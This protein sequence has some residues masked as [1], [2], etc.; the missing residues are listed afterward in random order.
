MKKLLYFPLTILAVLFN[1]CA[2]LTHYYYQ[3]NAPEVSLFTEKNEVK[4]AGYLEASSNISS[5]GF[6]A[7]Y[8]LSD[9]FSLAAGGNIFSNARSSTVNGLSTGSW[10]GNYFEGAFGYYKNFEKLGVFEVY[11]GFGNGNQSHD[12]ADVRE[13]PSSGFF[14]IPTYTVTQLGN[15]NFS[16]NK[17]FLQPAYGISIVNC[18]DFAFYLRGSCLNFYGIQNSVVKGSTEYNNVEYI[19]NDRTAWMIE[20]GIVLRAGYK[21]VK[22]QM[23]FGL[24]GSSASYNY[25]SYYVGFGLQFSYSKKYFKENKKKESEKQ[26]LQDSPY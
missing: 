1:G 17:F 7:S 13:V 26:L 12:Y 8:S 24:T 22:F 3:Q 14:I 11:A 16:Y 6:Q 21:F 5:K 23:Q 20:P 18:F 15:G 2:S 10:S 4:A 19:K 25:D 9:K